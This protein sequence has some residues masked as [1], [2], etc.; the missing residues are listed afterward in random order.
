VLTPEALAA[1]LCIS[2]RQVQRLRA[3]GMPCVPVGARAV[4]YDLQACTAWLQSNPEALCPTASTAAA[5]TRSLSAS[6]VSAYTA[7][8]R[9]AALRVTPS[10]SSPNSAS[11]PSATPV[12][13]DARHLRSPDTAIHHAQRI[14]RWVELYRASQSRQ[15]VAHVVADMRGHYADG[16]INRSLGAL[17][18]ALRVAWE[19]GQCADDWSSHVRRLPEH[20]ARDVYLSVEQVA[21]IAAHAS[22]ATRAAIWIALLTGCRRGELLALRPADIGPDSITILAGNT[23]TLRTRT[24]PIVPALRPWLEHVP[25]ALNAEGLKS[26][27]RRAREAAGMP[28]VHFHDLRHSC[29]TILLSLDTPLD[30]VR[31]ILGH[32]TIKTTERYSHALVHRQ[33]Q[34]LEGLGALAALHQP[35]A[36]ASKAAA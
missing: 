10:S 3:A 28:Q 1:H 33:R 29:A 8:C 11:Q 23:K 7:A 21:H 2:T 9:R 31:D 32:T 17:K 19:R 18:R 20:N 14:G 34:A 24:V 13:A 15:C 16:T 4:R 35:P 12:A 30:V 6:A 26:G 5:A 27:F 36:P 25:L 22:Q